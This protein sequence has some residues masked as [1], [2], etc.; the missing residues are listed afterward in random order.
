MKEKYLNVLRELLESEEKDINK[1]YVELIST[2]LSL[3]NHSPAET[4]QKTLQYTKVAKD[5]KNSQ[6]NENKLR[7]EKII[8]ELEQ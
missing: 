3:I 6:T 4:A 2:P 8:K 7:L 5:Y 1:V